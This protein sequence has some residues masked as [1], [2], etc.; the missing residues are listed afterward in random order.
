MTYPGVKRR[1]RPDQ[2]VFRILRMIVTIILSPLMLIFG[3]DRFEATVARAIRK[4]AASLGALSAHL[5]RL[6][7]PYRN[8]D[9]Y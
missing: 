4:L 2:L 6:P 7:N 5:G 9:G 1:R 8:L 3:F